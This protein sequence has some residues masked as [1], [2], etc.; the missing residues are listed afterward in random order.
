MCMSFSFLCWSNSWNLSFDVLVT[1][2]LSLAVQG[3]IFTRRITHDGVVI[4]DLTR[5]K[6]GK[7]KV[8]S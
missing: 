1:H 3:T 5:G 6:R 4:E 2:Y 8:R 7:R